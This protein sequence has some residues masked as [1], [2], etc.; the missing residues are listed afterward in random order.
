MLDFEQLRRKVP[1]PMQLL[2]SHLLVM[3]LGAVL[4]LLVN[5]LYPT[6]L[7][8]TVELLLAGLLSVGFLSAATGRIIVQP[9]IQLE[10]SMQAFVSGDLAVRAATGTTPE[11]HRLNLSFNALAESL[12]QIEA[13]RQE[14]IDDLVHEIRTPITTIYGNLKLLQQEYADLV[15][16]EWMFQILEESQRLNRLAKDT[17]AVLSSNLRYLPIRFQ[18]VAI[19]PIVQQSM[20]LASALSH[21]T[22]EVALHCPVSLPKVYADPDRV[23]QILVNLIQNALIYTPAGTVTIRVWVEDHLLWIA[24]TD[25]GIGITAQELPHVFERA[26][27]SEKVQHLE[28]EG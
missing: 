17:R 19:L 9:L 5:Q 1:L 26:W 13:Q 2:I 6:H 24:V 23:K 18:S 28:P 25:T 10:K 8:E 22:V 11:L 3:V 16:P 15:E 4:V 20:M 14:L 7:G 21:A 12:Q 27:R